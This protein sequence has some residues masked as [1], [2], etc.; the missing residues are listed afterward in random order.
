MFKQAIRKFSTEYKPIYTT[1]EYMNLYI[2]NSKEKFDILNSKVESQ[3]NMHNKIIFG[4]V[5]MLLGAIGWS[6]KKTDDKI[7]HLENEIKK[8][9]DEIKQIIIEALTKNKDK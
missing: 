8:N 3:I 1:K 5:G 6:I 4:S 9:N 2:N 7:E